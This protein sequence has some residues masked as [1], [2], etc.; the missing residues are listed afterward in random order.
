M[1]RDDFL[2]V[3][4]YRP[5]K[6]NECV[7]PSDLQEPFSDFVDQGKLP[8]LIF[9]GGPGTGKTTAAMALCEE[10]QTDYL[11]VNGSDEGRNIDTVRTTLN[12]FCSAISMTGNRKAIIMDEADYMNPDSVQPA[13]RGFIEKF[14]NNVSFIFTCNYPNRI[15]EPIHSRCAVIDF[16]IPSNEKP[17]IAENYLQLC[18]GILE[19]EGV[20]FDRKVLIQLIMKHFPD[21]RRVLNELQ[22]YS[23]SGKID[24]GIL[25]S[26]EELNVG[27]LVE[28]LKTKRFSDMRKWTNS[29]MDSDTTRIFRKLYDSLSSYLKPQSVPQAVLIIADY[30]YKSAFV[31]DQE[32]NM[33]ACLTE[34][35]VECAFK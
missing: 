1:Q 26:L 25:S 6:I 7:L 4:K 16:L 20:E 33:V 3:A 19:K 2:W 31:A 15:I 29:N 30:Q 8:N 32:I 28:S 5:T 24:T 12:Q 23:S 10:T 11:M 14:G 9:A 13:L 21:F 22:R 18:E 35:M 27:E 17:K 34:I